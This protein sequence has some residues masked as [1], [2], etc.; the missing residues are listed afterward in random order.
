[1][2]PQVE[3]PVKN[4]ALSENRGYSKCR[5]TNNCFHMLFGILLSAEY[6]IKTED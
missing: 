6:N 5:P 4:A 1:V 2:G 3:D